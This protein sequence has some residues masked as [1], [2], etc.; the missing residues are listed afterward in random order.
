MSTMSL[1]TLILQNNL[2]IFNGPMRLPSDSNHYFMF[3]KGIKCYRN[4]IET[5]H[6]ILE[7]KIKNLKKWSL[8][9]WKVT[10]GG[11]T[12]LAHDGP[13]VLKLR[14]SVAPCFSHLGEL[15]F[16]KKCW[17]IYKLCIIEWY[18]NANI[19]LR[20]WIVMSEYKKP[21]TLHE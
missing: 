4:H 17:E 20:S 6:N 13:I 18:S 12:H 21:L 15:L 8:S 14:P 1:S 10:T 16:A 7:L 3:Q 11:R 19:L 9:Y 2:I 5:S